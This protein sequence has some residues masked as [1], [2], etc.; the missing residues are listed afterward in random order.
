MHKR[1]TVKIADIRMN[2][3]FNLLLM[4]QHNVNHTTCNKNPTCMHKKS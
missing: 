4:T 1:G 3:E 2:K